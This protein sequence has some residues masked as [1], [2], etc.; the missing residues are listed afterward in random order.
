MTNGKEKEKERESSLAIVVGC[1]GVSRGE[2][3]NVSED[4]F[5]RDDATQS[6][7]ESDVDA[8][9]R[10]QTNLPVASHECETKT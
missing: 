7:E 2:L 10:A 5:F 4:V 9:V 8:K 6:S 3:L 1:F